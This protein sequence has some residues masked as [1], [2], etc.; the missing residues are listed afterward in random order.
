[1]IKQY[2]ASARVIAM[3]ASR[4]PQPRRATAAPFSQYNLHDGRQM[5]RRTLVTK[6]TYR[7]KEGQRLSADCYHT[8]PSTVSEQAPGRLHV[9]RPLNASTTISLLMRSHL[10]GPWHRAGHFETEHE[11]IHRER[12]NAIVLVS[13]ADHTRLV[14][15]L[16][17][18]LAA[19]SHSRVC[20]ATSG[21][22][23]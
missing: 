20:V 3:E 1:M 4:H 18:I 6:P 21:A 23:C 16:V 12:V 13:R 9:S 10:R 7:I 5:C 2:A 11:E 15:L 14:R 22:V 17:T 8:A 19:L